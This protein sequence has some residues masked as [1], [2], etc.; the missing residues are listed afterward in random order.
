MLLV[1]ILVG[2]KDVGNNAAVDATRAAP[3]RWEG[4]LAPA[5]HARRTVGEYVLAGSHATGMS[6]ALI[7]GSERG[8]GE[9]NAVRPCEGVGGSRG[10]EVTGHQTVVPGPTLDYLLPSHQ[11]CDPD[12]TNKSNTLTNT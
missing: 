6:T 11:L 12:L 10:G 7:G 1:R 9:P 4:Q 2:P 5:T 3:L 8:Q